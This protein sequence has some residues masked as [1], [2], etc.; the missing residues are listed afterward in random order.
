MDADED[1]ATTPFFPDLTGPSD[2]CP[3]PVRSG[4]KAVVF[5]DLTGFW[6][7]WSISSSD[8]AAALFRDAGANRRRRD[9]GMYA[10]FAFGI[11]RININ[12]A[13]RAQN[14]AFARRRNEKESL[15]LIG[16]QSE[17]SCW[18]NIG[19][20]TNIEPKLPSP[21]GSPN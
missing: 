18:Y 5:P 19:Y 2:P 20:G 4:K 21:P 16:R 6:D 13:W 9:C 3:G 11:A 7:E 14:F 17:T 12:F 15:F 10:Y 8:Y 1:V